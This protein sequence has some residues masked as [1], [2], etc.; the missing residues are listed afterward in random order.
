M[1]LFGFCDE[2]FQRFGRSGPFRTMFFAKA[3][4]FPRCRS[5]NTEPEGQKCIGMQGPWEKTHGSIQVY[6]VMWLL[7]QLLPEIPVVF[8]ERLGEGRFL[9]AV[10]L[11]SL[12]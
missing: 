4:S 3:R 1:N 7:C 10:S 8:P 9:G 6:V 5:L 12:T 2:S 11:S